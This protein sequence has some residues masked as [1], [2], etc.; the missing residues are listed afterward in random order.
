MTKAFQYFITVVILV[1]FSIVVNA[2]GFPRLPKIPDIGFPKPSETTETSSTSEKVAGAGVGCAIGGAAGYFGAKEL[3]DYLREEGYSEDDVDKAASLAAGVGCVL[4]GSTALSIIENMD[5]QS[6]QKQEDAWQQA[7]ENDDNEPVRWE[8]P[9]GTGYSG[10]VAIETSEPLADGSQCFTRKDYVLA[11]D[12]EA[13]V[14]NR[15]CK[16]ETDQYV[17]IEA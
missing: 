3:G 7:L 5:E 2:Q 1:G 15:Y 12:G 10:T 17:L 13:T 9:R 16:N 11:S 6:K 4:G 8:G 14:F